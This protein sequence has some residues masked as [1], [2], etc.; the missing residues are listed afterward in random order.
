M[1]QN[2]F[3]VRTVADFITSLEPFLKANL[4]CNIIEDKDDDYDLFPAE[5]MVYGIEDNS[6][7]R[8]HLCFAKSIKTLQKINKQIKKELGEEN[9]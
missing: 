4:S 9:E 2:K 3:K 8:I 5:V 7:M 1:K 6:K